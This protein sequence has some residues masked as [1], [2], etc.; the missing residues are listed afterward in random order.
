MN[1]IETKILKNT[2][3]NS[4]NKI[5]RFITTLLLAIMV[6]RLLGPS[7][8]GT[9]TLVSF[10]LIVASLLSNLGLGMAATKYVSEFSGKEKK[11][12]RTAIVK[13]LLKIKLV[14]TLFVVILL[15]SSAK[16]F[17]AFYSE[18]KLLGYLILSAISLLPGAL[19]DIYVSAIAGLQKFEYLAKGAIVISPIKIILSLYVLK[20]G[21]GINGVIIVSILVNVIEFVYY[22]SLI[23]SNSEFV[24]KKA[25]PLERRIKEKIFS[26]NWQIAIL[27]FTD[28]IVWQRSEVFFLAKFHDASEVAFYSVGYGLVEKGLTFIPSIFTSTLMPAM[29][30]LYGRKDQESLKKIFIKSTRLISLLV[31]PL[32]FILMAL[33]ENLIPM[34]F[35]RE[36]MP[37]A[38]IFK[39][40]LISGSLKVILSPA[41]AIA[42][43]HFI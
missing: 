8:F 41:S 11:E 13:Y 7:K 15:V 24:F 12:V 5:I 42:Q 25:P 39:I 19:T 34:M 23:I 29:S 6:A 26:Y 10:T 33:S 9:F 37:A 4:I 38:N 27:L 31:L 2:Y 16:F 35:G 22:Y 3:Y 32:C 14:S 17:A 30:E 43:W 1:V 28:A 20:M 18:Q 40:L 21:Y 36:Y